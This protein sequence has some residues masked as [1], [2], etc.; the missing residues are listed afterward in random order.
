MITCTKSKGAI[1]CAI[2]INNGKSVAIGS[3]DTNIYV[4]SI[5][6]G[7]L[8]A[9]L[10]GHSASICTLSNFNHFFA[11]G[12]DTG[13]CSL[14]IW[15]IAQLILKKKVKLHNAAVTCIVDLG[16]GVHLATAGYDKQIIVYNY[17]K[18]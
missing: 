1:L 7:N 16:D 14:A 13:C 6:N 17:M 18:G 2:F 3:R 15:D 12:G 10:S 8:Q 11:S 9:K 5:G 4:Y